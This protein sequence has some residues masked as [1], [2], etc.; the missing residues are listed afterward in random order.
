MRFLHRNNYVRDKEH[1]TQLQ[2]LKQANKSSNNDRFKVAFFGCKS[3]LR[4]MLYVR[5]KD[6]EDQML[7]MTKS[8]FSRCVWGP[9]TV[10]MTSKHML[11]GWLKMYSVKLRRSWGRKMGVVIWSPVKCPWILE[12]VKWFSWVL[13]A[14]QHCCWKAESLGKIESPSDPSSFTEAQ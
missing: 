5:K 4:S 1:R 13:I 2:N 9:V 3:Q 11:F 7:P 12:M 10:L 8:L 14:E 6:F